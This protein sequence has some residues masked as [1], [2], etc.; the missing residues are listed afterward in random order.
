ML[1]D[2]FA[3]Y[4]VMWGTDLFDYRAIR[5]VNLELLLQWLSPILTLKESCNYTHKG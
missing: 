3:R 4:G 5:I 1:N 2:E